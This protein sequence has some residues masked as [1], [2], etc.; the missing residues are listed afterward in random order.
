VL[1]GAALFGGTPIAAIFWLT[2]GVAAA[3]PR[4]A[5]AGQA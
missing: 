3:A 2:L 5:G 1:A 4:L